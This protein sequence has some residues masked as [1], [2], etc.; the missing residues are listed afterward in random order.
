MEEERTNDATILT[1]AT[2]LYLALLPLYPIG[3][4]ASLARLRWCFSHVAFP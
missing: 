4:S 1:V 3:T 2:V